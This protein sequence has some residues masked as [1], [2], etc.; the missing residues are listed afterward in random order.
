MFG[1]DAWYFCL[2]LAVA[3]CVRCLPVVFAEVLLGVRGA[4][5]VGNV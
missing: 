2:V 1:A 4:C 3:A 5:C